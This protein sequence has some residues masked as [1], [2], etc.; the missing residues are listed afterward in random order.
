MIIVGVAS[1]TRL[2]PGWPIALPRPDT[3]HIVAIAALADFHAHEQLHD[4]NRIAIP[5]TCPLHCQLVLRIGE[6]LFSVDEAHDVM[7]VSHHPVP[8]KLLQP[9]AFR[10]FNQNEVSD[11]P[12]SS[13]PFLAIPW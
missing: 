8:H 10:I 1:S 9:L 3:V 5:E 11:A 12:V 7:A 13:L 4:T 6:A 2:S